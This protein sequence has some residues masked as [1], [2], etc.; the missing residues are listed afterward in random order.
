MNVESRISKLEQRHGQEGACPHGVELRDDTGDEVA[1]DD[2]L[3]PGV[4]GVCGL[5]RRIYRLV[6]EGTGHELTN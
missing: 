2:T 5:P 3:P 6:D 1:A 4:C